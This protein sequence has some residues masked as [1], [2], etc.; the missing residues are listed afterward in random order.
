MIT[1]NSPA[2]KLAHTSVWASVNK[3]KQNE[4]FYSSSINQMTCKGNN[5][6][7]HHLTWP[8]STILHCHDGRFLYFLVIY[9]SILNIYTHHI[10]TRMSRV[11]EGVSEMARKNLQPWQWQ[12]I[13]GFKD[14]PERPAYQ[15][16]WHHLSPMLPDCW[17]STVLLIMLSLLFSRQLA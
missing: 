6:T 1:L 12:K 5:S 11:T 13:R 10:V 3:T 2:L 7:H 15:I 17:K 16:I 14:S 4:K 8:Q 9:T